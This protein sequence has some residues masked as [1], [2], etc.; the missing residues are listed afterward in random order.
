MIK[1]AMGEVIDIIKRTEKKQV[2]SILYE[3]KISRAINYLEMNPVLR[4]G[5]K[6][7]INYTATFLNL[8]SGGYDFILIPLNICNKN[9]KGHIMKLKYTPYQFSVES[10]EE[11]SSPYHEIFVEHKTL[12]GMPVFVGELHS[13]LPVL[14]TLIRQREK[15][16]NSPRKNITYIMT[17]GGALPIDLSDHVLRLKELGWLDNTITIGNAYGGD[18]EAI[19]IY[20]GLIAAKYAL[21]ADIIIVL[22]GPGMVGT[23]TLVGFSGVEQGII[24]NAV[25]TLKGMPIFITRASQSD[26][27]KRH[28]GISHHSLTTLKYICIEKCIVPYPKYFS[29]KYP[30]EYRD[31]LE[32]VNKKHRKEPIDID[33]KEVKRFINQYPDQI[34]TMNRN[35]DED[36]LFFDFIASA[37]YWLFA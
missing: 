36:P 8:G 21:K 14:V 15:A 29:K 33:H 26:K 3:N 22:M 23:G 30:G 28:R 32:V 4:Q 35:V 34:L 1:W 37:A 25:S 2:V 5:E 18:L 20:S 6:I 13:M 12:K 16:T 11:Q 19:N 17:D 7:I 24:I 10:C 9:S 31:L 27:R